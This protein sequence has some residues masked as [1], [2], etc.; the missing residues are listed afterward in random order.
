MRPVDRPHR[1]ISLD[2][3]LD[4]TRLEIRIHCA[5]PPCETPALLDAGEARALANAL[6]TMA[7]QLVAKP[8]QPALRLGRPVSIVAGG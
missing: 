5:E 1:W 7:D 8:T 2:H 3:V 4:R 6:L